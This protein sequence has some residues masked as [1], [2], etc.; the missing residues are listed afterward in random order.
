MARPRKYYVLLSLDAPPQ[1][2]T[3]SDAAR[4]AGHYGYGY[5]TLTDAQEYIAWWQYERQIEH[6]MSERYITKQ[7]RVQRTTYYRPGEE[8]PYLAYGDPPPSSP[9][10]T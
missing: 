1:I 4:K 6:A 3:G 10:Q 8:T 7:M 5:K 2:L 9:W